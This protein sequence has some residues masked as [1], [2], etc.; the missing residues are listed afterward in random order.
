M[1]TP[2]KWTRWTAGLL[3]ASFAVSAVAPAAEA[4]GNGR[5]YKVVDREA[6]GPIARH[7]GGV[8]VVE[9]HR[10]SV[11]GPAFAALIGGF[12]IGATIASAV[13][14]AS[15]PPPVVHAACPPPPPDY[16]YYDPYCGERFS[17]LEGYRDHLRWSRHPGIV[18]V[19]DDETGDCVHTYRYSHGDWVSADD[20]GFGD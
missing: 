12:A 6:C 3:L 18:R 4:H 16:Y 20:E 19:I 8:R 11:V 9:V 15:C 5:R 2:S 14:H 17:S 13:N 1:H 7:G 10:S